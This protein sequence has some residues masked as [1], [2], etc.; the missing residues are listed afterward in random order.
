M[1]R[2]RISL[3]PARQPATRVRPQ[4]AAS[5]GRDSA[6]R[7]EAKSKGRKR[8]QVFFPELSE[9]V[10]RRR[11]IE[12]DLRLALEHG[13]ITTAYQAIFD[14]QAQSVLGAEALI[15]WQH[16]VHGGLAPEV[17]TKCEI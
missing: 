8:H 6:T 15:R 3:H 12:Q 1:P 9:I 4:P 14:N 11:S 17:L 10:L 2:Q 5:K 16:P 7:T 13:S